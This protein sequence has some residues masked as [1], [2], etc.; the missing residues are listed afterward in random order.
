MSQR[1]PTDFEWNLMNTLRFYHRRKNIYHTLTRRTDLILCN[2][3]VKPIKDSTGHTKGL[4]TNHDKPQKFMAWPYLRQASISYEGP[5]V[6]ETRKEVL[7]Q[8]ATW[9]CK[10]INRNRGLLCAVEKED[11]QTMA[12]C[13]R[14]FTPAVIKDPTPLLE[15]PRRSSAKY[16]KINHRRY[17][18]G[19]VLRTLKK[20]KTIEFMFS[21]MIRHKIMLSL[22]LNPETVDRQALIDILLSPFF[23]EAKLKIANLLSGTDVA[24]KNSLPENSSIAQTSTSPI[25]SNKGVV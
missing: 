10:N 23:V 21:G 20:Q 16:R 15:L 4:S 1:K 9:F 8:A 11:I 13:L 19:R 14:H 12:A 7:E 3:F 5:M 17:R 22:G 24:T 25:A 6:G 2:V 18:F